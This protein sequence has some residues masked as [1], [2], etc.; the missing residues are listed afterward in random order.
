MIDVT[1]LYEQTILSDEWKDIEKLFERHSEVYL[2]CH[3]GNL[4]ICRHIATDLTRLTGGKKLICAP[5]TDTVSIWH[6]D[7]DYQKWLIEWLRPRLSNSNKMPLVIGVSSSG[8]SP[9]VD[10]ALMF[11]AS[12]GCDTC[13]I[14]SQ[15]V[16]NEWGSTEVSTG[17]THYYSSEVMTIMLFHRLM[18]ASGFESPVIKTVPNEQPARPRL[19]S[20]DDETY[21]IG[22]DFDGV[23]HKCSKGYYDGTI[24]DDPIDGAH[25]ALKNLS[26]RYTVIVYTCKAKSDRELVNGKT[27]TQLIWDWLKEHKLDQYISKVTA[28]KPRAVCYIDDKGIRFDGWKNCLENLKELKIL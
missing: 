15:S 13:Y 20:N 6:G 25:T 22:I 8:A 23:I 16:N 11:A 18:N 10:A 5:D 28:E 17:A 26:E 27:G 9:D 1:Q 19:H 21:Q 3:G 7:F 24:Y 2:V 4:S 12:T 14:T